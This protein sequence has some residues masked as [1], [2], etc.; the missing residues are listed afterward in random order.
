VSGYDGLTAT[1]TLA[2][3]GLAVGDPVQMIVTGRI[4]SATAGVSP[5]A[6]L[7]F[8]GSSTYAQARGNSRTS[9]DAYQLWSSDSSQNSFT[10]ETPVLPVPASTTGLTLLANLE[11]DNGAVVT[12]IL[13]SIQVVKVV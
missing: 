1:P 11:A 13:T 8:S 9:P 4:V 12:A 2:S 10:V 5:R 6:Y 7:S 3:L